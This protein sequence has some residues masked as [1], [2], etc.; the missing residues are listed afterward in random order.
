M[1]SYTKWI[2]DNR[3]LLSHENT[4]PYLNKR[5]KLQCP[6]EKPF[7]QGAQ[8]SDQFYTDVGDEDM[9]KRLVYEH[10]AVGIA[11]FADQY[12]QY[13][14]GG[15]L[16]GCSQNRKPYQ[17]HA[18]T[19]VGYGT[20]GGID[21]WLIKNSWAERWGDKGYIKVKRGVNACGIGWYIVTVDCKR[22]TGPTDAPITTQEPCFDT[23][24][25]CAEHAKTNCK[26]YGNGCQKSCGLCKGMTPHP[27]NTCPDYWPSCK[28]YFSKHC[29]VEMYREKCCMSCKGVST[30]KDRWPSKNCDRRRKL[31]CAKPRLAK[32]CRKTCG[33]C[34]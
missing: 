12:F 26:F 19:V 28:T 11:L 3:R 23:F 10:G 32:M 21:Y 31:Y 22:T 9:L 27:S 30:C 15:I 14:G 25:N 16:T 6:R 24:E 2:V 20:E 7:R 33:L 8:V 13:Y 4:N 1:Y 17:N 18:V 5:P 29:D 34:Q